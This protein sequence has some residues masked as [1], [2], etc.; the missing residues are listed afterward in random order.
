MLIMNPKELL[1]GLVVILAVAVPALAQVDD[2][3]SELEFYKSFFEQSSGQTIE[4][5]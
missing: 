4:K 3:N 2:N 1:R 5:Q